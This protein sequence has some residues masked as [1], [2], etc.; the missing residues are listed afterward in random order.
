MLSAA[1]ALILHFFSGASVAI[2]AVPLPN[3]E[4]PVSQV[5]GCI[6][7]CRG[8]RS[9]AGLSSSSA[10]GVVWAL[11][12]GKAVSSRLCFVHAD[13]STASVWGVAMHQD[14]KK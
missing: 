14:Q 12:S 8:Q 2:F 11:V 1:A 9:K 6:M 5:L 7:K 3:R 13:S 10:L 4:Q